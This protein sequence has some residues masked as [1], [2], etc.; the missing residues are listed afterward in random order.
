MFA[1]V[2]AYGRK[3][4]KSEVLI[5][6]PIKEEW[7]ILLSS[8]NQVESNSFKGNYAGKYFIKLCCIIV[9]GNLGKNPLSQSYYIKSQYCII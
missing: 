4:Q 2:V 6:R 3:Q 7:E 5:I 8:T 9:E 1:S